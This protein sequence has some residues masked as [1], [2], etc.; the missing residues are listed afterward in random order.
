MMMYPQTRIPRL[1]AFRSA[2]IAAALFLVASAAMA[3]SWTT[4]QN[5]APGNVQLML[6]LPDGT[7]MAAESGT[8]SNW[9]KLTP[10]TSGSYVNGTW[11]TLRP[12]ASTRLW[13]TLGYPA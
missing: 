1:W 2:L 12:M 11:S 6:L 10:D 8:S 4:L 7:V 5:A 13:Y 9:Y 3:G